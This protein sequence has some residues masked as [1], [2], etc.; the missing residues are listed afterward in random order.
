MNTGHEISPEYPG[1]AG[2]PFQNERARPLFAC[3]DRIQTATLNRLECLCLLC[4]LRNA[5]AIKLHE[6]IPHAQ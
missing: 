6:S 2:Q 5:R 1:Q 3:S 4:S